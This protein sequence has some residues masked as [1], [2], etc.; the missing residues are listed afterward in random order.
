MYN[1]YIVRTKESEIGVPLLDEQHSSLTSTINS[2]Y[3]SMN[4][5]HPQK[6]L[7]AT[8]EA[9]E[10]L[11]GI[12]FIVEEE[13]MEIIKYPYLQKHIDAHVKVRDQL[14]TMLVKNKRSASPNDLID[15]FKKNWVPHMDTFDR[16]YAKFIHDHYAKTP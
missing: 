14:H 2:L 7:L 6:L 13:I 1:L 8:I 5:G 11:A 4:R 12:H 15:Y 9:F 3:F 16:H 10:V